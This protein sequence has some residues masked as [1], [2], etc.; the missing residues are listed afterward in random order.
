MGNVTMD[1]LF[2]LHDKVDEVTV[3]SRSSLLNSKFSN[4]KIRKILDLYEIKHNVENLNIL[5][6]ENRSEKSRKN[7]FQ[8]FA[9]NKKLP[10][11]KLFFDSKIKQIDDFVT[12][13]I[14]NNEY[15][16][17][18]DNVIS[19]LGFEPSQFS[20]NDNKNVYKIGWCKKP[21]GDLSTLKI[22][23]EILADKIKL[24]HNL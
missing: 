19:S 18:F 6:T 1:L 15:S 3:L 10:K 13:K 5:K 24:D 14:N 12:Y 21:I 9:Q 16:E 4:D 2:Y 7:I 17:K 11:L 8:N 22:E 20:V 23:S